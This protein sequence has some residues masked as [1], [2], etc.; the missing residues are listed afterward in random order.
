MTQNSGSTALNS[1]AFRL[2]RGWKDAIQ[3]R[4]T[5]AANEDDSYDRAARQEEET[6]DTLV[7]FVEA[8]DLQ[9]SMYD[10]RDYDSALPGDLIDGLLAASVAEET[11]AL[12]RTSPIVRDHDLRRARLFRAAAEYIKQTAER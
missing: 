11:S 1:H 6:Y 12:T 8:N 4:E 5:A 2:Y 9:H 3:N 7:E 10:P